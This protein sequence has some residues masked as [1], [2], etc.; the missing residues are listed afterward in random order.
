MCS[1]SRDRGKGA[2][3]CLESYDVG[4]L[5]EFLKQKV[6]SNNS[7]CED[8]LGMRYKERNPPLHL[9]LGTGLRIHGM[10]A[11]SQV[12]WESLR[13]GDSYLG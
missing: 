4:R 13:S 7:Q 8:F 1:P 9:A 5:L 11:V 2:P 10:E 3:L 12:K 6:L